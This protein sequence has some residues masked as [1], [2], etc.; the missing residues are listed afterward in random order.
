[1]L[2]SE[3]VNSLVVKSEASEIVEGV[4]D[5]PRRRLRLKLNLICTSPGS[6]NQSCVC[7]ETALK[8]QWKE[9]QTIATG[10]K[11]LRMVYKLDT[12]VLTTQTWE[13]S[14]KCYG[15]P[16]WLLLIGPHV[17]QVCSALSLG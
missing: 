8:I 13:Q 14:N 5:L 15:F 10:S 6:F 1:M 9:K 17:P 2:I 4:P 7:F 11:W 16:V 3:P 12:I